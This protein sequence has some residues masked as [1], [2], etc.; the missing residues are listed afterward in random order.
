[1]DTQVNPRLCDGSTA[2]CVYRVEIGGLVEIWSWCE[3]AT[4]VGWY[5]RVSLLEV[6]FKCTKT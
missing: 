4:D 5:V 2:R 6:M 1:M 3:A